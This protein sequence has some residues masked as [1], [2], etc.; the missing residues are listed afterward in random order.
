MEKDILSKYWKPTIGSYYK[1]SGE[2][3]ISYIH[4]KEIVPTAY[5][6]EL[7]SVVIYDSFSYEIKSEYKERGYVAPISA[8]ETPPKKITKKTFDSLKTDVFNLTK[9]IK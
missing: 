3:Y 1:F 7:V 4:V 8:K 2:F 9:V 5:I 6:G